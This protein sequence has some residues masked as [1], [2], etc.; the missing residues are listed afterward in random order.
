MGFEIVDGT[1]AG[2]RAE[3]NDNNELVTLARS[4]SL[5]HVISSRDG[6]AYQ[7]IGTA[8][9]AA[10]TVVGLHIKNNSSTKD[11]V[12]T[13]IRHQ[14]VDE[15][16]GTA[17]PNASNYFRIAM[18]R[19]Y[20]SGGSTATPVN[21]NAASGNSADVTVYQGA[22]TLAGTAAEID[23][24]YTKAEAD[25]NTFNKEGA[26]ILGQ[27]DTLEL[28]YVGDQTGGTLYC[29]LSFVMQDKDDS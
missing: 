14:I 13:Y 27:D 20:S 18:D 2:N 1:G 12:V 9:L 25:M 19:T 28:S 29:R 7:V 4:I 24:W 22:P 8:S 17:L 16:G 26:V 11:L 5:Q 3:V 10:A 6:Q 21:V 23:R 15:S